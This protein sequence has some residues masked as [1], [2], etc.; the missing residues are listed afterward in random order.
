MVEA[1][2][3]LVG[4]GRYTRFQVVAAPEF[5]TVPD[6]WYPLI[7]LAAGDQTSPGEVIVKEVPDAKPPLTAVYRMVRP[8]GTDYGIEENGTLLDQSGRPVLVATG[9]ILRASPAGAARLDLTEAQ[10]EHGQ[11]QVREAYRT[12]WSASEMLPPHPTRAI[13]VDT[14]S[15]RIASDDPRPVGNLGRVLG[16]V[17]VAA[18]LIVGAGVALSATGRH[19]PATPPSPTSAS[20]PCP[21]VTQHERVISASPTPIPTL[22]TV[23]AT[24]P[25]PQ[26]VASTNQPSNTASCQR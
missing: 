17:G 1:W 10:T 19:S 26:K 6:Q 2:P 4:R 13:R 25:S 20:R 8:R 23:P 21:T 12:V 22:T 5:L 11:D 24:A 18:V 14:R 15:D 7:K 16:A 3:F 9:L